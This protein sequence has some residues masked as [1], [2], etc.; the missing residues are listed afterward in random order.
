M[1]KSE[2]TIEK[3]LFRLISDSQLAK[4]V[5]G[6]VYR[7]GMRPDGS[8]SEDIVVKFLTGT[9]G[10]IQTGVVV[11]NIYVPDIV[12]KTSGKNLENTS[13]VEQL[14]D[15]VIGFVQDCRDVEYLYELDG[16]PQSF[17]VE[18][19][20]QHAVTARIHYQRVTN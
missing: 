13:R 12:T 17:A 9:E 8:K 4:M 3:D 5:N 10:Q 6:K 15:A 14:E 11:V 1:T 19:I 18:E 16:T 7:A 2:K 20:G